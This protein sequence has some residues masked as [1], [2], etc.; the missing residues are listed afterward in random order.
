MK[1]INYLFA[2]ILSV[3]FSVNTYAQDKQQKDAYNVLC[4]G[5]YNFEN[6]FD[7]IDTDN[8]RDTEFTPKGARAYNTKIYNEKLQN[9]SYVISK[10]GTD[11]T[12]DGAAVLGVCEIENKSVLEDFCK[13][14]KIKDRNYQ[15]VHYDSPD[16]RGIDVGLLYNPKYFE[17]I[18]S[19]KIT[20]KLFYDPENEGKDVSKR[21]TVFT[22]DMLW[23]KGKLD[24]DEIYVIV[25]HWPSRRGG[26]YLREG[27]AKFCKIFTDSIMK[28]D[29]KAKIFVMGD[30]NDYPV[31][32]SVKKVM[33]AKPTKEATKAGQ[34]FN[35]AW[36]FHK[37]GLG[38]HAWN[39]AWS[40]F[41]QILVSH[42]T[43]NDDEGY[44]FW[45]FD[46]F[47]RN[48]LVNQTG[49]YKGYPFRTYVGDTYQ[50][51]YSD[52]LPVCVYLIKKK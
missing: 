47:Y 2:F 9:L 7:T 43:L 21:D 51:G 23:V 42:G 46:R 27:A 10:L 24:G 44:R 11:K 22:R 12:P 35:P 48:Y 32:P 33:G 4:L 50:G 40:V 18:T 1:R 15:I 39:D 38:T 26:S 17:V 36:D 28:E 25:C 16:K 13:Q 29:P 5:F 20:P 37:K 49:R 8:V 45:K 3:L 30:L 34:F 6:L 31:S 41:D 14:E 52:H 19:G